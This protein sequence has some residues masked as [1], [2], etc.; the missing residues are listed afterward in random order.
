MAI[1]RNRD[2]QLNSALHCITSLGCVQGCTIRTWG[3][4]R[5]LGMQRMGQ[6]AGMPTHDSEKWSMCWPGPPTGI[7]LATDLSIAPYR[8]G[9]SVPSSPS[10]PAATTEPANRPSNSFNRKCLAIQGKSHREFLAQPFMADSER[11][12]GPRNLTE[13]P[14]KKQRTG[15]TALACNNCRQRKS[16]CSGQWPSCSACTRRAQVCE[17]ASS[18][19]A[20]LLA[21]A[22]NATSLGDDGDLTGVANITPLQW[23]FPEIIF[24]KARKTLTS[25]C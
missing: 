21:R 14:S 13:R 1:L 25:N 5:E 12:A 17:Y 7:P 15:R 10:T 11:N 6:R 24:P 9:Y 4:G 2:R 8:G 22:N 23:Y 16:R 18:D 3:N 19:S 20:F